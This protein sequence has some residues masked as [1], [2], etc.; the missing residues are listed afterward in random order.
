MT[1]NVL[2]FPTRIVDLYRIFQVF[3]KVTISQQLMQIEIQKFTSLYR[4]ARSYVMR[5]TSSLYFVP[6]IYW[7]FPK[8]CTE[9]VITPK[10]MQIEEAKLS[11]ECHMPRLS[12]ALDIITLACTVDLLEISKVLH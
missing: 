9:V 3:E 7:K 4:Q 8:F 1:Y 2:T 10:P 6:L 5:S 12:N 11:R